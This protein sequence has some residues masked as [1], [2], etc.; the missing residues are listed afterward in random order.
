MLPSSPSKTDGVEEGGS[1]TA[2]GDKTEDS[3]DSLLIDEG[4]GIPPLESYE[5]VRV[6]YRALSTKGLQRILPKGGPW[7]FFGWQLVRPHHKAVIITEGEYDA[8]AVAQALMMLQ[9]DDDEDAADSVV[10]AAMAKLPTAT[11]AVN[12]DTTTDPETLEDSSSSS[13]S[14]STTT[15]E[16]KKKT[17]KLPKTKKAKKSSEAPPPLDLP[18]LQVAISHIPSMQFFSHQSY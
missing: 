7:G 13:S 11:V 18:A 1:Q 17:L 10:T 5:T 15:K 14:S 9:P 2:T 12:N 16:T 3:A 8:M 6:K 4:R